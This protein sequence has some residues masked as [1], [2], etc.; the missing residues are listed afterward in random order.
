V[1]PEAVD[2]GAH[3]RRIRRRAAP[4]TANPSV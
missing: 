3:A 1:L 4:A 2:D